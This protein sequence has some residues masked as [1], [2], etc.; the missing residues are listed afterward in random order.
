MDKTVRYRVAVSLTLFAFLL[1][2]LPAA[3]SEPDASANVEETEDFTAVSR[4]EEVTQGEMVTA[5]SSATSCAWARVE[6]YWKNAVGQKLFSYY[7]KVDWCYDGTTITSVNRT[8]WAET[9]ALW[10]QFN[11]HIANTTSGG[12][13]K[14]NYRAFTQGSFSLCIGWQSI[15]CLQHKYPWIDM[16]VRANGTWNYTGG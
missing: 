8:R 6:N 10:W 1:S 9:Y 14:A 3:A 15:G 4:G 16:T 13:G 11:G 12:A 2:A 5:L 7:Q